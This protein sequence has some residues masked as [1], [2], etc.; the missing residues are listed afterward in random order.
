MTSPAAGA[1]WAIGTARTISWSSNLAAGTT[2]RVDLSRDGGATW[3]AL[4]SASPASGSLAW[5]A[6]SPATTT[7]RVRVTAN[8]GVPAVGTSGAFT[9]GN[10]TLAVTSPAAAA[11]WTIGA[12][13]T[14][15]WTTNLLSTAT[16]KIELTRNGGTTYTTLASSRAQLG[17]LRLDRDG[18]GQYDREGARVGERV[19][20]QQ[21]E[22]HVLARQRQR[23]RDVPQHLRHLDDRHGA[24]DHLDAQRGRRRPVQD[25]GQPERRLV[26][27]HLGGD[28]RGRDV[29]QLQLDGR[30]AEGPATPRSVSPGTPTPLPRTAATSASRSTRKRHGRARSKP[31]RGPKKHSPVRAGEST[32]SRRRLA[33]GR[34]LISWRAAGNYQGI[35]RS[36]GHR[37]SQTIRHTGLP[38]FRNRRR[39]GPVVCGPGAAGRRRRRP[40][41]AGEGLRGARA[42][43]ATAACRVSRAARPAA[44]ARLSGAASTSG[45][46]R[47]AADGVRRSGRSRH[48]RPVRTGDA[49][50][51]WHD[52]RL[53]LS[54]RRRRVRRHG[55]GRERRPRPGLH[56]AR[57]EARW[58]R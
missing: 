13:Q 42:R 56:A 17:K 12:A 55:P 39:R 26:D 27:H 33:G 45:A 40:T 34:S 3:T 22:Q 23:H 25:R 30:R 15:T 58:R 49:D 31:S 29:G 14:I 24:R 51:A 48:Q 44:A 16:V 50:R 46:R 6:T 35:H 10:P 9:I 1:N 47:A 38:R 41:R 37:E 5:T 36:G 57:R 21:H 53:H 19:H 4:A 32:P 8:G 28:G 18:S 7:A 54:Q 2:V 11:K 20:G 43:A 52:G